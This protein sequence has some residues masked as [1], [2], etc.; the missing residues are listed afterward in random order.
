[1]RKLLMILVAVFLMMILTAKASDHKKEKLKATKQ[2][3]FTLNFDN[4]FDAVDAKNKKVIPLEQ[5]GFTLVDGVKGKALS[6]MGDGSLKY[7]AKGLFNNR[8]G[9]I[10]Y[11]GK[12]D[13]S[14]IKKIKAD[15][16]FA[17]GRND[18][19]FR[20]V[21]DKANKISARMNPRHPSINFAVKNSKATKNYIRNTQQKDD[22]W[23]HFALCWYDGKPARFFV[24][25]MPYVSGFSAGDRDG[26]LVNADVETVKELIFDPKSNIIVDEVKIYDRPLTNT[27]VLKE[28]RSVMPIDLVMENAV[29]YAGKPASIT[30]QAAPGGFFQRP[31]PVPNQPLNK[32]EVTLAFKLLAPDGKQVAEETQTVKV[33]KKINVKLKA[34]TLPVGLY[35]LFCTVGYNGNT[36]VREFPVY[37]ENPIP[38][39][40]T[41]G[42]DGEWKIGEKYKTIKFDNV[43][44]LIHVTGKPMIR[45]SP[46][47]SYLEM[48]ENN[49][50]RAF[51]EIKF[52]TDMIGKPCVLEFVWPDDKPRMTGLYMY[53]PRG[54]NRDRLGVIINSGGEYP[55][56]N[57]MRTT[58][59]TF[60][61]GMDS[62]LF[63]IRTAGARYPAALSELNIFRMDP[64]FP[65][66]KVREPQGLPPRRFGHFDED[67]TFDYTLC[68]DTKLPAK[69]SNRN[70]Y[71]TDVL[72]NYMN[73]VGMNGFEYAI[74]RY[75]FGYDVVENGVISGMYPY[76]IGQ[77]GY[78]LD[79]FAA[80]DKKFFGIIQPVYVPQLKYHELTDNDYKKRGFC[81][82]DFY[83]NE[84]RV[85]HLS[86]R[87]NPCNPG[88]QKLLFEN[89]RNLLANY[90]KHPALSGLV[91]TD[92][93]LDWGSLD[94]G[95]DDYT[96]NRFSKDTGIKVPA[97][98]LKERHKFLTGAKRAEWLKWRADVITRNAA[99]YRKLV[100]EYNPNL[101]VYL[102]V[103]DREENYVE[104]GVD[105]A[106]IRKI[107]GLKIG[108]SRSLYSYRYNCHRGFPESERNFIFDNYDDPSIKLMRDNG[109]VPFINMDE[110]Y[111]ETFLNTPDKK[112][113]C[114]FQNANGKPL[115]R[116]YLKELAFVVGSMD[117]RNIMIG[118]QPLST[119]G[120]ENESREFARAFRALPALP[121]KQ[122]AGVT[123]PATVRCLSTKNGT[124]FYVV[125]MSFFPV[126]VSLDIEPKSILGFGGASY[127]DLSTG[128]TL[129]GDE[130]E[131]L[132]FQ[133]RSFL[134][135]DKDFKIKSAVVKGRSEKAESYFKKRIATLEDTAAILEKNNIPCAFERKAIDEVRN[136]V[137]TGHWADAHR[138]AFAPILNKMIRKTR[139][140]DKIARQQS[141]I[142]KG[143]YA[144]NC[145]QYQFCE[146]DGKLFFPDQKFTGKNQYGYVGKNFLSGTRI[147]KDITD[148]EVPELYR[149][150]SFN[151]DGYRFTLPNGSYKLRLYMKSGYKRSFKPGVFKFGMRVNGGAQEII[152]LYELMGGDFNKALTLERNVEVN[153]GKLNIDFII[154]APEKGQIPRNGTERLLNGIEVIPVR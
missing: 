60:M 31:N 107:G 96:V 97:V 111:Y 63:E 148:T 154:L 76:G 106:A 70:A 68:V 124:Y 95:Y 29:V 83:G 91:I 79:A 25:G 146:Y 23:Y 4:G 9:T 139:Q 94:N 51:M 5:S 2:P 24:N 142:S 45:N 73:Y 55:L 132:P 13:G 35:S 128:K 34:L 16:T 74:Y 22:N 89:F 126:T 17:H 57:K 87:S 42:D 125:N 116:Y 14:I 6:H 77:L 93:T 50:D 119:H 52:P 36:Y 113:R 71:V 11:W 19:V 136:E 56:T 112:Y 133:L 92:Y 117:A 118:G 129:S 69:Y 44:K 120:V 66:L 27:E 1:M 80:N 39:T 10:M 144:V 149:T 122:V 138:L 75:Q 145:G 115:G 30:L 131:L 37:V 109:G 53:A 86:I 98:T 85:L 141:M 61:P 137:A 134:A 65:A 15:R 130:I 43:K 121:F 20:A 147:I 108:V 67:Q 140:L 8:Q 151:V 103:P 62:Y 54:A 41:S 58:R 99:N 135:E 47:G 28:Y 150:E 84:A 38:K 90:A 21:D 104:H 153:D 12:R 46:I 110:V 88:V 32:T 101:D 105:L 143:N 100:N 3:L 127:T 82:Q 48:G 81:L 26:M 59:F 33:D 7:P 72:M 64:K 102:L 40:T 18:S 152:D 78:I 123:D 49:H 114:Y